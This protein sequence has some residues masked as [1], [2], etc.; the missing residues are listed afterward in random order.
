MEMEL[1][2][3]VTIS[4]VEFKLVQEPDCDQGSDSNYQELTV[5]LVNNGMD[6]FPVLESERW[7]YDETD[8][9][10]FI[11]DLADMLNKLNDEAMKSDTDMP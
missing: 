3:G 6:F 1:G 7:A 5:R 8:S 4:D 10:K 9:F 11:G 2:K